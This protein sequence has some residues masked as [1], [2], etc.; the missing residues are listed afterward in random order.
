MLHLTYLDSNSWL[1]ELG[2]KRI[3]L[4][5]WLVGPL[6]FANLPW[7]FQGKRPE[8]REIPENLDLILLSQGLEDHTHP[9]TLKQL[10]RNLPVVA[11]PN[12]AKVVQE[13]GY[14]QIT[15]LAH[16]ERFT[17]DDLE[18]VAVPG[19]PIGPFLTENGYILEDKTHNTRLYYEPH[20]YHSPQLKNY[21]AVDVVITPLVNLQLPV[22][23]DFIR[24]QENALPAAE[25]LTPQVMIPTAAGGDIEYDG[26]INSL[27][28]KKGT[29]D[30]FRG[31]LR[32]KNLHIRI[33]EPTP[34]ERFGV[35][36]NN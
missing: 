30:D 20:G 2:T 28:E 9:P 16:G 24:G 21:P 4:D 36:I 11:S 29:I 12:A 19:A 26:L 15:P 31:L 14:Q 22:V 32:D 6:V 10:D 7:F 27:L 25:W 8:D 33:I 23:G 34:G 3:L 13:L 1:I 5:P 17:L 35:L 18:I